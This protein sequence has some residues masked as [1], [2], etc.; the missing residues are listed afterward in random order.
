MKMHNECYKKTNKQ[1]TIKKIKMATLEQY[2]KLGVL[3]S[4]GPWTTGQIASPWSQPC[5]QPCHFYHYCCSFAWCVRLCTPVDCS[6]PSFPVLHH[7]LELAQ[8]HVC[9]VMMPSKHL[10]LCHPLL[11]LSSIFSSIRV[12][13]KESVLCIRWPMY[14]SFRL[15]I[16]PSNEYS[17]LI[18]L[19]PETNVYGEA[20]ITFDVK[21]RTGKW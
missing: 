21:R 9:W 10:I 5:S 19:E 18:S 6:S 20:E 3:L 17:G 14:W 4:M 7:L 13:S 11:L 16:S 1:T 15:S 12:F 2:I 8:T